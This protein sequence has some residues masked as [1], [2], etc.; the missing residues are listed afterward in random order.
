MKIRPNGTYGYDL[1]P[2]KN[3]DGTYFDDVVDISDE[4]FALLQSGDKIWKNGQ[5]VENAEAEQYKQAIT[6]RQKILGW[7]TTIAKDK[8][9]LRQKDYIGIKIAHAILLNDTQVLQEIKEKYQD[10]LT[11]CAN[12]RAEINQLES[13]IAESQQTIQLLNG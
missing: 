3:P 8:E 12:K 7:E 4:D 10:E 11:E 13:Q 9:Y 2:L 5:L 6:E 1:F